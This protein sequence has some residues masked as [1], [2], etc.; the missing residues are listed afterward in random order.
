M[1][2]CVQS[3][4]NS[5]PFTTHT[6]CMNQI[7][8]PNES[9]YNPNS[10][11]F[12][13]PVFLC[14]CVLMHLIVFMVMRRTYREKRK[15]RYRWIDLL[16]KRASEKHNSLVKWNIFVVS[17]KQSNRKWIA[18]FR[19]YDNKIIVRKDLYLEILIHRRPSFVC[20]FFI[21]IFMVLFLVF[22]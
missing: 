16:M 5:L 20:I 11:I 21:N 3:F 17:N 19:F 4:S 6:V 1:R 2:A 12:I 7:A 8:I 22:A 14:L 13:H 18:Y 15:D 10:P 9:N